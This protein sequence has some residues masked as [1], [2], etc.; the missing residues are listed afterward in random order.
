MKE[1]NAVALFRLSVLVPLVSRDHLE[2]GEL[3]TIIRQLASKEYAI[4]GSDRRL[5]GEKP[6]RLG[7]M[8]GVHM[9]SKA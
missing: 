2:R 3:Q 9:A 1:F 4:P 8:P 6:L 5:L 7:I